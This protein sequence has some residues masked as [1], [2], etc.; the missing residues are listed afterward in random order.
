MVGNHHLARDISDCAWGQLFGFLDY[1]AEYAG[2]LIF[3]DNPRNTSKMCHVCGAINKDLKLSDR[4]W[5][6]LKCGTLHDRD[7]NAAINHKNEGIKYLERLGQSHQE[8]TYESA[9][10]V[11]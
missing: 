1:K 11:S 5:V 9:Q 2:R 3:R 6:C 10:C 8:L 7:F 4:T